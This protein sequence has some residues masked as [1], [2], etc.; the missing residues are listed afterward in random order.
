M[1]LIVPM[2][3]AIAGFAIG[4]FLCAYTF[5][6]N[7]GHY[8]PINEGLYLILC[9]PS[10]AAMALGDIGQVVSII[11]WAVISLLNGV[12]YGLCG[13]VLNF[14]LRIQQK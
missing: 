2:W 8:A 4:E 9:P 14:L 7:S 1:K 5:Y 13:L 6:S 12:L 10:I 3:F 11:S